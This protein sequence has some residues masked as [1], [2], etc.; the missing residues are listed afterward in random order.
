MSYENNRQ[1][2]KKENSIMLAPTLP[3][4]IMIL[5]I[6]SNEIQTQNH[7]TQKYNN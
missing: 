7:K 3:N 5:P 4:S 1:A 2:A 6:K